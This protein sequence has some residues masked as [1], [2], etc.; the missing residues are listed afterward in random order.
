MTKSRSTVTCFA[1]CHGIGSRPIQL[2]ST[3][4]LP[5]NTVVGRSEFI[6]TTY[7]IGRQNLLYRG[8]CHLY[9]SGVLVW[10][11]SGDTA[12]VMLLLGETVH[13]TFMKNKVSLFIYLCILSLCEMC[14]YNS[15]T[16]TFYLNEKLY[17]THEIV[18]LL[19]I[20]VLFVF[21]LYN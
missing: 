8:D 18:V 19:L 2:N 12:G 9:I 11:S 4:F 16:F 17:R 3:L 5:N 6:N 21:Q 10:F 20:F 1:Y 15:L 7:T 13:K 14:L